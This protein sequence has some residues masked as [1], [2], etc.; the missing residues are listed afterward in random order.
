MPR[1][2][3]PAC[4]APPLHADTPTAR[5]HAARRATDWAQTYP[6]WGLA[7]NAAFVVGPRQLTAGHNL[8]R[9]SFLHSYDPHIDPDG[10][11]LETILTAPMVVAQWINCQYY[12][13]SVA[14][15][16][17]GAGTKTV[18]NAVGGVGVL[19]GPAGDLRIGLPWQSVGVG[20]APVHEPMRLLTV[21][22]APLSRLDTVI[23]RNPVLRRLFGNDWVALA[24]RQNPGEPWL[25]WRPDGWQPWS[26]SAA[27]LQ[28]A[29]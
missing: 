25:R 19:A 16:V 22:Q 17:F 29:S 24:A 14:P 3:A 20:T 15:Q 26:L 21:V 2:A 10:T 5:R 4:P 12:F 6:E 9:R 18:H 8:R 23:A 11:A 28:E 27:D 1:N 13:S 7:G